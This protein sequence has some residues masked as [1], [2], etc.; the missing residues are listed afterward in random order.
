M[1]D[2]TSGLF[3]KAL[4]SCD[5]AGLCSTSRAHSPQYSDGCDS[6][7]QVALTDPTQSTGNIMGT[8]CTC[9]ISSSHGGEYDVQSCVVGYYC[10]CLWE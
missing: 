5:V 7:Q 3:L 1:T 9:E 6:K 2:S 4:Y 10:G 8:Y